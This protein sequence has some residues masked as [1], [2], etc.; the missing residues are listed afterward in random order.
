MPANF[1]C[2]GVFGDEGT[3]SLALEGVLAPIVTLVLGW[4]LGVWFCCPWLLRLP[5]FRFSL[6]VC[7]PPT[8]FCCGVLGVLAFGIEGPWIF[9]P[10]IVN[11]YKVWRFF[12]RISWTS[13]LSTFFSTILV[14]RRFCSLSKTCSD[15][16]SFFSWWSWV[17]LRHCSHVC[18]S[19]L[20][21]VHGPFSSLKVAKVVGAGSICWS[22]R[23]TPSILVIN[24]IIAFWC[25]CW[26][27]GILVCT[28]SLWVTHVASSLLMSCKR[29]LRNFGASAYISLK[30]WGN[31]TRLF[32]IHVL[33]RTIWSSAKIALA[34][35]KWWNVILPCVS[36][37]LLVCS[38]YWR[39]QD[40]N[41][42]NLDALVKKVK[43]CIKVF[44]SESTVISVNRSPPCAR[45]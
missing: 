39:N 6:K 20:Q 28:L 34:I 22:L 19:C 25:W 13:L 24:V 18:V 45:I 37:I 3:D 27:W 35:I 12:A 36:I 17:R 4:N 5:T 10:P 11:L 16:T 38:M 32:R 21:Y 33:Y 30:R 9:R 14:R 43:F 31:S 1:F 7:C 29:P 26:T 8:L 44:M 15:P 2:F 41:V 40:S 42:L 23:S